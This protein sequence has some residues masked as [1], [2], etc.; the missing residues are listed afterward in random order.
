MTSIM[1]YSID[2]PLTSGHGHRKILHAA[3][4][5]D[6]GWDVSL[7]V[8]DRVVALKHCRDWHRVERLRTLIEAIATHKDSSFERNPSAAA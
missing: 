8:D 6:S 2:L 7:N 3:L 4:S 1:R 5:M